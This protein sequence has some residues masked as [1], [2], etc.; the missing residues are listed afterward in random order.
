MQCTARSRHALLSE[1][2]MTSAPCQTCWDLLCV[3]HVAFVRVVR[4]THGCMCLQIDLLDTEGKLAQLS[5]D[6]QT[7]ISSRHCVHPTVP[8]LAAG[9]ASGRMYIYR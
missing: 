4:I 1:S 9:T 3:V 7:A 2:V 6:F 8:V 5:S